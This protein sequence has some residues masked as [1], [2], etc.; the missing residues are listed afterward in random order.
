MMPAFERLIA[1]SAPSDR[2]VFPRANENI[3]VRISMSTGKRSF[4]ATVYTADISLSGV[5]F[6]STFFLKTGLVLDLEFAM[7]NDDRPVKVRGL[8]VREVRLDGRSGGRSGAIAGFAIRFT[9]Y[10]ADAKTILASSF[11]IAELDDF[12]GDYMDRRSHKPKNEHDSLRDVII[13]W[14]V[15]KMELSEGEL[16]IMRDRITVDKEGKIRRRRR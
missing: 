3:P 12:L 2:R 5:F 10:F 13:A 15:G 6:S 16:N 9:E 4:E 14:E 1:K 7:P 11:L 8:I